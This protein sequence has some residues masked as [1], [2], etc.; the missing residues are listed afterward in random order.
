MSERKRQLREWEEAR[1]EWVTITEH[2]RFNTD[3][4][5]D[6]IKVVEDEV[7]SFEHFDKSPFFRID[8]EI[9]WIIQTGRGCDLRENTSDGE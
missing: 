1:R 5:S 4:S 6:H 7:L 3:G 2:I 8:P 9:A